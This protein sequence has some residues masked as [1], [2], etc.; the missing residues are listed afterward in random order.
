[1]GHVLKCKLLQTFPVITVQVW[2]FSGVDRNDLK[3]SL[4][5]PEIFLFMNVKVL[6]LVICL[7]SV[8]LYVT[9]H[10]VM[11][12]CLCVIFGRSQHEKIN[13]KERDPE[14]RPE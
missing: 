2:I 3:Y 7:S 5:I 13:D 9:R 10:L 12:E 11:Y 1:M 4:R 8:I 14:L 6:F